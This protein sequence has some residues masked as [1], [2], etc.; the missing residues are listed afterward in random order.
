MRGCLLV[1]AV[2]SQTYILLEFTTSIEETVRATFAGRLLSQT[3]KRATIPLLGTYQ[4]Y[5][6]GSRGSRTYSSSES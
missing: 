3:A 2:A 4:G 1:D 5:L 6:Q